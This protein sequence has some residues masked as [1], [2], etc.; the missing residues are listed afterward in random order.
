DESFWP[1]KLRPRSFE[2]QRR[3]V[4]WRKGCPRCRIIAL[5]HGLKKYHPAVPALPPALV[6]RF[7][8]RPVEPSVST[9]RGQFRALVYPSARASSSEQNSFGTFFVLM[10][11]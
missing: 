2:R 10:L 8:D 1:V 3:M 7:S 4:A 6:C 9:Q 11:S 5:F